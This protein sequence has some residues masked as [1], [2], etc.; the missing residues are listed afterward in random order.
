M[1][2]GKCGV[3]NDDGAQ[4]CKNCGAPLTAAPAA[5]QASAPPAKQ[6]DHKKI[7]IIATAAAALLVVIILI[8]LLGGRSAEK[9]AGKFID[10]IF[11]A[12]GKTIVSLI[13]KDMVD[14]LFAQLGFDAKGELVDFM[15][16]KLKGSTEY[17]DR[18]YENWSYSYKVI[19]TEDYGGKALSNL[20]D[21]YKTA[22]DFEVTAAKT[23]SVKVTIKYDGSS[24]TETLDINTIKVGGSW[25]IDYLSMGGYLF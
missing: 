1:F 6:P 17:Y 14:D 4:F 16:E 23:V 18:A 5:D 10:A 15:S 8:V 11:H 24:D 3:P 7:G 22:F 2:C 13:P 9:T 25:Y 20:S 12:D 21:R 19:E